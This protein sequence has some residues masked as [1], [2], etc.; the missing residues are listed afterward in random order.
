MSGQPVSARADWDRITA[1]VPQVISLTVVGAGMIIVSAISYQH[2]YELARHNGQAPWVSTLLPFT[3]DGVIF[4]SGVALL[5]A[6]LSRVRGWRRL[7]Q[8][9]GV[10]A[11]G[12]VTTIAANLFSDYRLKW[13]GPAV[14]ASSGVALVLMSAVA[15]WLVAEQRKIARGDDPQPEAGHVCPPPPVSLAEA[16]PLAKGELRDRGQMHG[17]QAL[18]DGFLVT[19]HVVRTTLAQ[20]VAPSDAA[21]TELARAVPA[22]PAALN[23]DGPHG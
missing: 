7:W 13:L 3:L 2:E 10:L 21:G 4:V 11:V 23:G 5:W 22:A 17:E 9:R 19:R 1:V 18:A 15:F 12:M 16:L 20:T 14:S 6:A 8:P